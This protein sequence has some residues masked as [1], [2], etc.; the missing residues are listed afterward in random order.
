[1]HYTENNAHA[2]QSTGGVDGVSLLGV[3]LYIAV[4]WVFGVLWAQQHW[5]TLKHLNNHQLERVHLLSN[6]C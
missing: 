5:K 4:T 1:M 2:L 6:F 3:F